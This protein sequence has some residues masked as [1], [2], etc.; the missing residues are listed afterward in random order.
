[1]AMTLYE[2]TLAAPNIIRFEL[3]E[4][5]LVKPSIRD[6]TAAELQVGGVFEPFTILSVSNANPAVFTA[7]KSISPL[8]NDDF[9]RIAKAQGKTD[10]NTTAKLA[11]VSGATFTLKV[12]NSA[13][14]YIDY[15]GAH[16][17]AALEA[18]LD[19]L[20]LAHTFLAA[21]AQSG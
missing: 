4:P 12:Q 3:R 1:M 17:G 11:N 10:I 14:S 20:P 8:V 9:V 18:W 19:K 16:G 15:N 6:A 13:G 21:V 2:T 7:S 5:D